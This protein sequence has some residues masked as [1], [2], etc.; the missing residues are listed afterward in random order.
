MALPSKKSHKTDLGT[1]TL[2]LTAAALLAACGSGDG[3]SDPVTPVP[4]V[5]AALT[6]S[7]TA[8]TGAAL[9]NRPVDAKCAAGT[10]APV[11]TGADGKYTVTITGGALP[12]VLRV[13]AADG[14]VLHSLATGS[15]ATAAA[16]ITPASEL[17]VAH[18]V[19]GPAAGAYGSFDAASITDA[20]VQA[21]L[22]AVGDM[23]KAG[24]VDVTA[25]GNL[26]TAPLVAANGSTAGNDFDKALDALKA[27]LAATGTTL[28]TLADGV[29]KAS[30]NL[31][32]TA[33]STTPSLPAVQL[34][35]PAAANCAALR[36]GRY[37]L[38]VNAIGDGN[39]PATEVITINATLLTVTNAAGEVNQL[40]ANGPCRY[41]TPQNGD[42]VVSP[43]GV[44]VAQIG[45][46]PQGAALKGG[47]LFPEQTHPLAGLAGDWNLIGLDRTEDNGPIHLTAA[48][49]TLNATGQITAFTQ[50]D[51]VVDGCSSGTAADV[52]NLKVTANPTGGF[53]FTNTSNTPVDVDRL[54]AYRSG[55]G[56]LVWVLLSKNGHIQFA[57][58][59][60]ALTLPAVGRVS[61]SFNLTLTPQYT[62]PFAISD[63]KNTIVS[64]DATANTFLRDAVTNL[65]TGVT[66]PERFAINQPREGYSLRTG[67]AVV[68][69]AGQP[70]TVSS[71]VAMTLR[72]TGVVPV[73]L[74][75]NNQLV[76]SV[77][78]P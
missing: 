32:A 42:A 12:C 52:A 20:K 57:T 60:V 65:T 58:R 22:T 35:Q 13:T 72:G 15:G 33:T 30:P 19:G 76:L 71:F 47:L 62:A 1:L 21:A 7:G 16:N 69:S 26:L 37:R 74:L 70:S 61:E 50:C 68:D 56:E 43:A 41:R 66:R 64:V 46:G 36:S 25:I 77:S 54:F 51:N 49:A 10:A 5:P 31:P 9:A 44:I 38:V 6:L 17:V 3:S 75:A 4:V 27:K 73:A 45:Y 40:T 23:L 18:L 28:A 14:S 39:A 53:D 24:G 34:L 29:A 2:A 11:N 8:A 48:T 59:K 55:G 63:S 78:K 67:E